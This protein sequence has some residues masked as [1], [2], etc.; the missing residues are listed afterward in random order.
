MYQ[1]P[2]ALRTER[3]CGSEWKLR[4]AKGHMKGLRNSLEG[5]KK[6][7]NE[8]NEMREKLEDRRMSFVCD[9]LLL[10]LRKDDSCD[11]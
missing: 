6:W 10:H 8:L 3:L 4:Q 1:Q 11:D 9:S 7:C 2:A 5:S